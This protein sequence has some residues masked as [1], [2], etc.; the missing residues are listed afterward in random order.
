MNITDHHRIMVIGANGSGK[1]F[2]ARKLAE[3]TSLPLTHLD[4]EF[5]RPNWQVPTHEEWMERNQELIADKR[6]IIDGM[7]SHGGTMELRY[8]AAELVIILDINRFVC[9]FGVI[10]RAGKPREDMPPFLWHSRGPRFLRLC[11]RALLF[12]AESQFKSMR[13][14]Y[15]ETPV[16]VIHSRREMNRLLNKWSAQF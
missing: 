14:T 7:C 3:I 4:C 12:N 6:W 9:M 1:S 13:E 11:K 5:W 10:K 8:A 2:F 15:P 16:F